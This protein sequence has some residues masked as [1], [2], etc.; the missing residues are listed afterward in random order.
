MKNSYKAFAL[1]AVI[2]L[3]AGCVETAAPLND[4]QTT[5]PATAPAAASSKRLDLSGSGLEKVPSSVFSKTDL[6]EL[7]LSG[8]RLTG[9]L[10]GEIRL[11]Q[12]LR[13]LDASDNDMTGV[14]AEIGQLSSL[15]TLDL[16]NNRLTGLPMELGNLKNLRTLDLRGNDVSKQDLEGI[17]AKLT[18][19]VILTD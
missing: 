4:S 8:N 10:P 16:S 13:V 17:R 6:E 15:Q 11:L 2:L 14:P 19:T 12:R 1:A 7:N 5:N 9:A 3:G 18:S